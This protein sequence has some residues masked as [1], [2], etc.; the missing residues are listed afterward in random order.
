MENIAD[1]NAAKRLNEILCCFIKCYVRCAQV[2]CLLFIGK[3]PYSKNILC[4]VAL[5]RA[6]L[7]RFKVIAWRRPYCLNDA[8]VH[9][10][11]SSLLPGNI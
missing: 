5:E 4:F 6:K 3:I 2:V 10:A 9:L 11:S 1:N 8:A 7:R